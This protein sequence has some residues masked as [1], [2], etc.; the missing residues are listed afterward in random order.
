MTN[1]NFNIDID[2]NTEQIDEAVE[3][4][5]ELG[6]T[7]DEITPKLVIRNSK[8]CTFNITINK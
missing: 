1:E 4:A 2:V 3:K 8:N 7:L 5:Q 6:N